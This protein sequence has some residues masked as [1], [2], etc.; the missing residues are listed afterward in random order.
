MSFSLVNGGVFY[1]S[2]SS[3]GLLTWS[4]HRQVVPLAS[5][6]AVQTCMNASARK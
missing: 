3:A 6:A 1:Q 4:R 5:P 2:M